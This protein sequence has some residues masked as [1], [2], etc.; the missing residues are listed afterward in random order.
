MVA[1]KGKFAFNAFREIWVYIFFSKTV[2]VKD[3]KLFIMLPKLL[4]INIKI[5]VS[6]ENARN[7]VAG[8]NLVCDPLIPKEPLQFRTGRPLLECRDRVC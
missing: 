5:D 4:R 6:Y 8:S 2:L 1:R 7:I 3:V